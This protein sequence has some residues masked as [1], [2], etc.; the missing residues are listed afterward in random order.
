MLFTFTMTRPNGANGQQP[1]CPPATV[2]AA[3]NSALDAAR[4]LT[5]PDTLRRVLGH[6]QPVLPVLADAA[7]LG[8]AGGW[9]VHG[10]LTLAQ[11]A[12]DENR[13]SSAH[14]RPAPAEDR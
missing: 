8:I 11:H 4:Q 10:L 1:I 5:E 2:T 12:L 6:A 7:G 9:L 3:L 14:A 13:R